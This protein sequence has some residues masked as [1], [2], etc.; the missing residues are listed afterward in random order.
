[1]PKTM[2]TTKRSRPTGKRT[3]APRATTPPPPVTAPASD[4]PTVGA[5]F[6]GHMRTT[7]WYRS[8]LADRVPKRHKLTRGVAHLV[9]GVVKIAGYAVAGAGIGAIE[10]GRRVS[11]VVRRHVKRSTAPKWSGHRLAK[12]ERK[13]PWWRIRHIV[14][15]AC[16]ATFHDMAELNKHYGDKHRNETRVFPKHKPTIHPTYMR[17]TAGKV[18]V[19]PVPNTPTGRHRTHRS[20]AGHH[21]ASAMV[22]VARKRVEERG[23]K[24]MTDGTSTAARVGRA[25]VEVGDTVPRG[26]DDV[27]DIISG[28]AQAASA[29]G[30]ALEL[31][32]LT[33]VKRLNVDPLV[34][35]G[36][37]PI[38]ALAEVETEA[39]TAVWNTIETI[40][41]PYLALLRSGVAVPNS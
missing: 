33:L 39:F 10:G 19:R 25:W 28:L 37:D 31:L 18:K 4:K 6:V 9:L 2:K 26:T 1:M 32:Q 24:V 20:T 36:L 35:K 30:E 21:K 14:T 23:K 12:V 41:G 34:A 15:C 22:A 17:R 5:R 27:M 7:R 13:G 11:P 3:R 29:R 16:G 8:K 38:I 40:Y